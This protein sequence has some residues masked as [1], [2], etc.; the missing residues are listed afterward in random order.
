MLCLA[1]RHASP[2]SALFRD[3]RDRL[4]A[5]GEPVKA[6]IVATARKLL[7]TLNAM[8]ATGTDF[9]QSLHT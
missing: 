6:A 4:A 1:A 9:D 7:V 2:R 5:A 3:F 8:P